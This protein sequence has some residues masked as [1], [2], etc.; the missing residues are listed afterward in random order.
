MRFIVHS[1][2][3]AR[4]II[5]SSP[6]L[7]TLWL[8]LEGALESLSDSALLSDY[9][10]RVRAKLDAGGIPPRSLSYSIND[11]LDKYLVLRGWQRQ[12]ALFS[13][14]PYTDKNDTRWRLDFSKSLELSESSARRME[15]SKKLCGM[16][17]EV[18]FNHGEAIA[19]NLLK[20]VMAAELN[21]VAKAT[22][23]GEGVG[24][25]VTATSDLKAAGGFD[26]AV[27]EYEKVLRY[28]NP[29]RNQLT[30]PMLIV[31]LGSPDSFRLKKV[32]GRQA[33]EV[34]QF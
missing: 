27:G 25:I 9:N 32:G 7:L 18:A 2:R 15:T 8:E 3:N 26:G 1:H 23:I 30:T 31:G 14:E 12:S 5:D 11:I 13:E 16:A 19:W 29:M 33:S 21:H 6:E 34:I 20:P 17:V 28:L 22:D 10:N 24:V 4:E